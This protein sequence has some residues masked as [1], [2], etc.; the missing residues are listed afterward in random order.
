MLVI[1]ARAPRCCS[2]PVRAHP[3][4]PDVRARLMMGI[5]P[6]LVEVIRSFVEMNIRYFSVLQF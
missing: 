5:K 4:L 3:H 1:C 6:V 2:E